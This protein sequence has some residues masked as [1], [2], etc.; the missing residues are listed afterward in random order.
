MWEGAGAR[1]YQIVHLQV[2]LLLVSQGWNALK[3][4]VLGLTPLRFQ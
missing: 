1:Q 3:Q 4:R 2:V